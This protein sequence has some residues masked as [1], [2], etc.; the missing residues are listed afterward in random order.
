ME[1]SG[2]KPPSKMKAFK[3]IRKN[4]AMAGI[5]PKLATQSYP[6]NGKIRMHFLILGSAFTLTSMYISNIAETFSEYT[7]SIYFATVV[8]LYIF[9]L[10][11]LILSVD[12]LFDLINCFDCMI[13]ASKCNSFSNDPKFTKLHNSSMYAANPHRLMVSQDS[14]A[15]Y[16]WGRFL[17]VQ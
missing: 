11:I 12:K 2:Q 8:L 14:G 7:Q 4:F 6:L 10:V 15:K 13:N 3:T 1:N 17:T 5:S 16:F 9:S